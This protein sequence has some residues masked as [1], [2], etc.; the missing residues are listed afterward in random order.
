MGKSEGRKESDSGDG[1]GRCRRGADN[2]K[3]RLGRTNQTRK[4]IHSKEM[5]KETKPTE[6]RWW[7]KSMTR[8]LLW[9]MATTTDKTDG[10]DNNNDIIRGWQLGFGGGRR[11]SG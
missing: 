9:L 1:E 11:E 10:G 7:Q 3:E 4:W 5:R 6:T 8:Q 2:K